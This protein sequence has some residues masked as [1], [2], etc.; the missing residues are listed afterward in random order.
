MYTVCMSC[1]DTYLHVLVCGR[2]DR[3]LA[4]GNGV[5]VHCPGRGRGRGRRAQQQLGRHETTTITAHP[6]SNRS[7]VTV[8]GLNLVRTP[9]ATTCMHAVYVLR[10]RSSICRG[11]G[12]HSQC[13]WRNCAIKSLTHQLTPVLVTYVSNTYARL[14]ALDRAAGASQRWLVSA[15]PKH[16]K[17]QQSHAKRKMAAS[18]VPGGT[19][20]LRAH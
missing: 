18:C 17:S 8:D 14:Q 13:I 9:S 19:S 4:D 11:L 3:L 12:D 5:R 10:T 1:S 16:A 7:S 2:L 15:A 6:S 20:W